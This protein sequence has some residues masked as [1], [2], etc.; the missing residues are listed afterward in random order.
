MATP[1]KID[2]IKLKR[3]VRQGKSVTQIAEKFNVSPS[4]VSQ[5]LKTLDL[6]I[7]KVQQLETAH[8]CVVESL[9]CVNQLFKI[10]EHANWLLDVLVDWCKGEKYAVELLK[11]HHDLGFAG[12]K[13]VRGL[14]FEDPK[15]L[16]LK[17]MRHIQEQLRLQIT[18]FNSVSNFEAVADFQRE[19]IELIGEMDQNLK[20]KFVTRLR[21][22]RSIRAA[23]RF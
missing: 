21:E 16:V 1:A 18:I 2:P 22:K 17:V 11:K 7:A 5:R 23:V 20:E 3:M 4:A 6:Q 14:Q 13:G 19:L 8:A 9:D 10:N 15:I 12:L